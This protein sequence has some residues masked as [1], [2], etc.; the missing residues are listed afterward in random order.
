VNDA[1]AY[2]VKQF[3]KL[4]A[5]QYSIANAISIML[6]IKTHKKHKNRQNSKNKI[7]ITEIKVAP[8]FWP[9]EYSLRTSL[10]F[11][12]RN[13]NASKLLGYKKCRRWLQMIPAREKACF[14]ADNKR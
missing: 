11:A 5:I 13:T 9:I 10:L 6:N 4:F 12:F 7:V 2:M 14:D 1:I 3:V 8:Y